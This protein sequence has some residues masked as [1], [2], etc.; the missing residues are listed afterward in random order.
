MLYA[1][2]LKIYREISD[3]NCCQQLQ[4][5][6]DV[7]S[8][9]CHNNQMTLNTAKCSVISFSRKRCPTV[10]TYRINDV[11]LQRLQNVKD[12]GVIFDDQLTF[13]QHYE[14]IITR[15]NQMLGFIARVSKDFKRESLFVLYKSMVRS[16][17]EYACPIWSPF[18]MVH[19]QSIER[20]Q[21]R[22]LK[23]V[24]QRCRLGRRLPNYESRLSWFQLDSLEHKEKDTI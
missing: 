11:A 18:Y 12:L 17:L 14:Q 6:L 10:F 4:N 5:D 1:D 20:V 16:V 22:F 7:L 21:N 24:S 19:I 3:S 9:W 13:R 15:A 23:I 2:D 8:E